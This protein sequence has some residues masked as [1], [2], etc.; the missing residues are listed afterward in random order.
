MFTYGKICNGMTICAIPQKINGNLFRV[1]YSIARKGDNF[2]KKMGRT[3]SEGRARSENSIEIRSSNFQ[4]LRVLV[5]DFA[6][7]KLSEIIFR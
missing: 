6:T 5:E 1:G 4:E 7:N 2:N 3:I